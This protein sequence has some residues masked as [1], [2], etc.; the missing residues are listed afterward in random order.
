VPT[1]PPPDT[2]LLTRL[3]TWPQRHQLLVDVLI[4]LGLWLFF[5]VTTG[6]Q[7]PDYLLVGTAQTLPLVLRRHAPVAVCTVV[8]LACALQ[9]TIG[10]PM[11]SD[12]GFLFATSP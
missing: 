12:V 10:R 1:E 3:Y 6:P 8:S 11:T 5:F 7:G 4:G 2:G 9:L